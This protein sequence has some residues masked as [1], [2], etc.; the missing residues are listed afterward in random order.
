MAIEAYLQSWP[1]P[2]PNRDQNRDQIS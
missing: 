2:G 1:K